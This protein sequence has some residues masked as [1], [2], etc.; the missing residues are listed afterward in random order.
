MN[1][2]Y[3]NQMS[4]YNAGQAQ[5]SGV[6]SALG[7]AAGLGMQ[8]Y[9]LADGGIVPDDLHPAWVLAA[10][11]VAPDDMDGD[12]QHMGG[13]IP[14]NAS[15]SRGA[16]TDDIPARLNAGEF[17]VP[18][19]AVSWFGEKHFQTL[20]QKAQKEKSEAPGKPEMKNVQPQR[21][22]VNTTSQSRAI[23]V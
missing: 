18:K 9:G 22:I 11:G 15:P 23:P 2:Q 13:A 17:I 21:P 1:A 5:S 7:L 4:Q 20:I 8:A 6:G 12:E 10:G 14:V 19:E 3:G 16:E